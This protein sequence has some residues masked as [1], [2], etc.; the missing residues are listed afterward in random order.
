MFKFY[1]LDD[2]IEH[3]TS[4]HS[5]SHF[6]I[7]IFPIDELLKP[8]Y[9]LNPTFICKLTIFAVSVSL[10]FILY[11]TIQGDNEPDGIINS[12]HNTFSKKA[13]HF[14]FSSQLFSEIQ[15]LSELADQ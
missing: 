13:G 9:V 3:N 11:K 15:G 14:N 4:F 10:S 5:S 7:Q 6:A 1:F 12:S 2:D 8:Y